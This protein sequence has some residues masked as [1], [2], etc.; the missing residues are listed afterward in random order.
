MNAMIHSNSIPEGPNPVVPEG[1]T[2]LV[3][4]AEARLLEQILPLVRRQSV[5]LDLG[6]VER[7]DAA[8]IAALITLYRA[9]SDAGHCFGVINPTPHVGEVLRLV[10]LDRF[11]MSESSTESGCPEPEMAQSAA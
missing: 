9:A 10:G 8:G 6:G 5:W 1:V 4:G 11:L 2:S 3:R 7:I